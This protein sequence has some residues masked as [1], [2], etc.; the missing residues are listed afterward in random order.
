VRAA[1]RAPRFSVADLLAPQ[2]FVNMH[3]DAILLFYC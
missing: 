1:T 3:H 2:P